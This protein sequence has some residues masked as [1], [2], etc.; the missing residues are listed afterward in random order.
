MQS[1]RPMPPDAGG[2]ILAEL[3][4]RL[5]P[6]VEPCAALGAVACAM[7]ALFGANAMKAHTHE[8]LR[9]IAHCLEPC[10]V[11]RGDN[12][13]LEYREDVYVR[14]G[15]HLGVALSE[16][17][18]IVEDVL[19]AVRLRL[20]KASVASLMRQL[21]DDFRD[22]WHREAFGEPHP[23]FGDVERRVVLPRGIDGRCVVTY[24]MSI[25]L[26]R[27]SRGNARR[28]VESLPHEVRPLFEP[29]LAV[30]AESADLMTKDE[31]LGHVAQQLHTPMPELVMQAVIQSV[32]RYVRPD[33][34]EHVRAQLPLE[35]KEMWNVA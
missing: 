23:M 20:P 34:V 14:V 32:I 11:H 5:P 8:E 2:D 31:M 16:A 13:V 17:E 33:V 12:H 27:L 1:P 24:V 21:P 15:G 19:R 10:N 26:D 3:A 28:V 30:R 25:I 7:S 9:S 18:H 4:R 29:R 6:S 35:L 22:M